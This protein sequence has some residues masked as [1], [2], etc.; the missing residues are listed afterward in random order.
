MSDY[1]MAHIRENLNANKEFL[2]QKNK[3][4]ACLENKLKKYNCIF[5]SVIF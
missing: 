2:E 1:I 4:A 5:Y 3:Q